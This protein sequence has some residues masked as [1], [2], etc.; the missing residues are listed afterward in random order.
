MICQL[1]K[2]AGFPP[3]VVNA[4]CGY[5]PDCGAAIASH[6]DI[7]K[8]ACSGSTKTGCKIV[9]ASSESNLKQVSLELGGKSPLIICAHA[10]LDNAVEISHLGLFLNAGQ[11]CC[12]SSHIFVHEYIHDAFVARSVERLNTYKLGTTEGTDQGLQ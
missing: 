10:D 4:L 11:C 12:A 8:V 1:I 7:G 3:C 5:G 2:G 9:Q 6:P